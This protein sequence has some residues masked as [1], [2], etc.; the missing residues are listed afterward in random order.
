VIEPDADLPARRPRP[1]GHPAGAARRIVEVLRWIPLGAV[2]GVLAGL[3]SAA[4]LVSLEWATTTREDHPWLLWLLPPAGVAV[5]ALGHHLGGRAVAGTGLI[6]DEI[7]SP[8]AWLPR[9]LG[10]L[11]YAGTIVT[12]LFG[13]SA[14][15]EGTALQLSGSLTDQVNRRLHLGPDDRRVMLIA[16][17][18]GGFGA[19][20]G[21][22]LAGIVFGLEV[23]APL[24]W[25]LRRSTVH[26]R[27][28]LI[29]LVPS[30]VAA[31]VGDR[32]VRLLGITH[33]ATL[34]L[35]GINLDAGLVAR[36]AATGAACGITALVFVALTHGVR[37]AIAHL[38]GW[39]PLRL[40]LGGA[41]VV[42]LTLVVGTHDYLGL[43][44]PLA[45][46]ALAG[47]TVVLG[48]FALKLLFTAVTVGSGFPGGEVTPL[49]VIGATLG[50]TMAT[51]LGVPGPLLA[52]VGFVA[53][54][55]GAADAPLA[56]AVMGYELFG[57][58]ALP[59]VALGCAVSWAC[60]SSRS[61]YA[62][63]HHKP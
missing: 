10:P 43:S 6:L 31:V 29:A 1:D 44:L 23:Q 14:G 53:V 33:A 55:A 2:V 22:P 48:A 42:G 13:G 47:G 8:T 26:R 60:S 25:R 63:H 3:S 58:G 50:A 9:R 39:P 56:C 35:N 40:G 7:H 49:F 38:P 28:P 5:G 51:V 54:F 11:V 15:R 36:V 12:H 19:V 30:A 4:F 16:A 45:G 27:P 62:R 17:L 41:G 32:V 18:G 52:A 24:R 34:R 37:S 21:V 59:L 20:F 61:I 46:A 57:A